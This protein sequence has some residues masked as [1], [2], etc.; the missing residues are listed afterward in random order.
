VPDSD[1][2]KRNLPIKVT[3]VSEGF[4]ALY[5]PSAYERRVGETLDELLTPLG[6]RDP[7]RLIGW[8]LLG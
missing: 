2:K 5:L 6:G 7:D 1:Q 8:Q 4:A 3:P